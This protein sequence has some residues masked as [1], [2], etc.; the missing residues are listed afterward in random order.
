METTRAR[1]SGWRREAGA[2]AEALVATPEMQRLGRIAQNAL[3]GGGLAGRGY[4]RL[5][6][7]AGTYRLAC[8][9]MARTE[10]HIE[11]EPERAR[12]F[13][14]AALVHDAGHGPLSHWFEDLTEGSA[15][16]APHEAWTRAIVTGDTALAGTLRALDPALPE[17]ITALLDEAGPP[18]PMRAAL[19]GA[20]DVDRLDYAMRDQRWLAP[21]QRTVL[22]A[23]ATLEEMARAMAAR[24]EGRPK[25]APGP[26]ARALARVRATLHASAYAE[27]K[28]AED[29]LVA[30]MRATAVRHANT[31]RGER[32]ALVRF[33]TAPRATLEGYLALDDRCVYGAGGALA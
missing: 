29:A 27:R 2:L 7:C 25:P 14:I 24:I 1:E 12:T 17:A 33:L 3:A 10:R 20:L 5:T 26:A 11:I 30:R 19:T 18:D 31:A 23:Q 15:L 6:H 8:A 4:S 16:A 13:A 22:D 28:D 21:A 9:L 32:F